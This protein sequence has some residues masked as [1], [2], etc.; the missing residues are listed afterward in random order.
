MNVWTNNINNTPVVYPWLSQNIECDICIV[1]GGLSALITA[2]RLQESNKNIVVVTTT[3]IG[4]SNTVKSSGIAD[5]YTNGGF[6]KLCNSIGVSDTVQYYKKMIVGINTIKEIVTRHNIDCDLSVRDVFCFTNDTDKINDFS[7]EYL[8]LKHNGFEINEISNQEC[9][10]I[11]G[12]ECEKGFI[13]RNGGITLNPYKL[14]RGLADTLTNNNIKIY[15]N[16]TVESTSNCGNYTD[17]QTSTGFCIKCQKVVFA[18]GIESKN[19]INGCGFK[20]NIYNIATD[21]IDNLNVWT[22]KEIIHCIDK[23]Y[24]T[25]FMTND[26]NIVA[27]GLDSIIQDDFNIKGFK[28]FTQFRY[29][30][31]NQLENI[32]SKMFPIIENT[33]IKYKYTCASI[34]NYDDIALCGVLENKKNHYYTVCGGVNTLMQSL[35]SA[36]VL[37]SG[38]TILSEDDNFVGLLS[39]K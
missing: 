21:I 38:N 2:L 10:D 8:P 7:K 19:F 28:P 31:L 32:V 18:T 29:N 36:D 26:N 33:S 1:G 9:I 4:N 34:Q 24:I 25:C 37:C 22:N 5:I 6:Q 17:L 3:P 23:P 16:T 20:K 35:L 15:E 30:K 13:L 12:F 39:D 27:L 11:F 14:A